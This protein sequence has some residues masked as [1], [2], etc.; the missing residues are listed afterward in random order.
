M[1]GLIEP[2]SGATRC[3]VR[4]FAWE[5]AKLLAATTSCAGPATSR[6]R[7]VAGVA[8]LVAQHLTDDIRDRLDVEARVRIGRRLATGAGR[9]AR[10]IRQDV[11]EGLPP[12]VVRDDAGTPRTRASVT[13]DA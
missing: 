9:P 13:A 1:A 5:V 7:S 11:E 4:H 2:G 6:S 8:E 12:T 3:C 10:G